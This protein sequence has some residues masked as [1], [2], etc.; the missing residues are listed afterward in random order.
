M[1]SAPNAQGCVYQPRIGSLC[2][3]CDLRLLQANALAQILVDL[4]GSS[5]ELVNL[6]CAGIRFNDGQPLGLV[7]GFQTFLDGFICQGRGCAELA[8]L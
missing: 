8:G 2:G 4:P 1:K 7:R 5:I 3:Q 6:V